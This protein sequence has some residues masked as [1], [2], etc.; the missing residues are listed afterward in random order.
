MPAPSASFPSL[1]PS[2]FIKSKMAAYYEN[3]HSRTKYTCTVG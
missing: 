2:T 1:L 3:V